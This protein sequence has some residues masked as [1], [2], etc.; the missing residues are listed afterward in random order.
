MNPLIKVPVRYGI[1]A[2][3]LGAILVAGLYYMGRHPYLIPVFFDFRIVLFG[4]FIFFSLK[5][6]RDYYQE[7]VLYFWQGLIGSFLFTTSFAIVA[8][9]LIGLFILAF[10]EFLSDYI[11]LSLEQLRG[12]PQ[13]VIDRIGKEVYER[14]LQLLPSTNTTDLASL[15]FWQSFMIGLFISII[16]SVILR[17]QPKP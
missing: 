2:G 10:P 6:V 1:I 3:V 15:Y 12:L 9:T 11:A 13:D 14:N 17:R 8:S 16:L 4:V 7:G 5:E